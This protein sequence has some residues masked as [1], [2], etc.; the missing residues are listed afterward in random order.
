MDIEQTH[1]LTGDAW[2]AAKQYME[3]DADAEGR[4]LLGSRKN[5][6]LTSNPLSVRAMQKHIAHLG[7]WE[8]GLPGLSPP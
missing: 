6:R 2:R 7:K 3:L 1:Q 4:V 5:G 8:L